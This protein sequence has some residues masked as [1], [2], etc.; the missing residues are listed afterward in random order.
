MIME[1]IV[2][3]IL[4]DTNMIIECIVSSQIIMYKSSQIIM[5]NYKTIIYN[6]DYVMYSLFYKY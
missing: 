6:Y 5:Y 1:C 4:V 3:T 2:F